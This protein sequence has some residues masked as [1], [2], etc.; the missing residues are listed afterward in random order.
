MKIG[1]ESE[2]AMIAV[3]Y[4]AQHSEDGLIKAITISKTYD[5]P[6]EYFLKVMQKLSK[7]NVLKSKRGLGGGFT[8]AK[9]AKEISL[10]EII[11][12]IK[13]PS[14]PISFLSK[15]TKNAPFAVNIEQVCNDATAKA[16]SR[17]GKTTIAKMIG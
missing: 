6:H 4:V 5:I 15:Q 13:G 7:A 11:E 10:L 2:Y 16:Q 8:L 14:L 12:A 1:L 9:P 3:A 17:F